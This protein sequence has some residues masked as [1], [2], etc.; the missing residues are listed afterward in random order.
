[1]S[2]T[3]TKDRP[4]VPIEAYAG[5]V[6]PKL[7][8]GQQEYWGTNLPRLEQIKAQLDPNDVFHNPQSVRPANSSSAEPS[9]S[10]SA[11]SAGPSNG[12]SSSR[13]EALR[14]GWYWILWSSFVGIVPMLARNAWR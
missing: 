3:L 5:Y 12:S 6:D 7:T 9:A 1:M 13:A 11:A 14:V 8:D 2:N 4:G 10:A